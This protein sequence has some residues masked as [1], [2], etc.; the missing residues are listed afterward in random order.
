MKNLKP[1]LKLLI[2]VY[3]LQS[4]ILM[5]INCNNWSKHDRETIILIFAILIIPIFLYN[6]SNKLK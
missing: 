2:F 4:F 3:L 5:S 1:Y 6:E